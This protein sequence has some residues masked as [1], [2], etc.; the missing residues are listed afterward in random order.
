MTTV[1]LIDWVFSTPLNTALALSIGAY[2]IYVLYL[3]DRYYFSPLRQEHD[4]IKYG[5][6]HR[7]NGYWLQYSHH[8]HRLLGFVAKQ[9]GDKTQPD[10]LD[11][12][13]LLDWLMLRRE[14]LE[15][16]IAQEKIFHAFTALE[17]YLR[18]A[19]EPEMYPILHLLCREFSINK[20]ELLRFD[21]C[22]LGSD[23]GGEIPTHRF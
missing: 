19:N 20:D 13:Y 8:M 16:W 5:R 23:R 4:R 22:A 12:R 2:C 21:L 11:C 6:A 18:G 17:L 1:P 15:H 7:L 9:A 3:A 14:F 10:L